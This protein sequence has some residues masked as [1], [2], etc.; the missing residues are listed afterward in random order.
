[1][2]VSFDSLGTGLG[3]QSN[4]DGRD[5]GCYEDMTGARMLDVELEETASTL[6]FYRRL[7]PNSGG[8]GYRRGG[9][10]I[11]SA[12]QMQGMQ[13]AQLTVFSNVTRIPSTSPGA[14]LPGSGTGNRIFAGGLGDGSPTEIGVRL[15]SPELDA[16]GEVPPSHATN[17]QIGVHDVMRTHSAG[18]SGLGDPLFREP[19]RVAEDLENEMITADV[20]PTIYGVVL[21]AD[22]QPDEDAT[23]QRR[24]EIRA[25]RLGAE[26]SHEPAPM[27]EY[28][29]PMRVEARR[30]VCN[31]CDQPIAATSGNWKDGAASRSWPL[32]DRVA[33]MGTKVRP[34]SVIAM[35]MWEHCCPSCGT[36]LEA[37]IW[38]EGE[39]P[40]HDV[41]LGETSDA[42]GEPF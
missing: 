16:G 11:D 10:A 21:G 32:D 36:L 42:P 9:M 18:G 37:E 27:D 14:G 13:K 29:S 31:H 30:F 25:E 33:D 35:A 20:V 34:T 24:R 28:R 19:W 23:A 4:V 3:A 15:R 40:A 39:A 12:W 17:L 1:V 8:H 2:W 6:H 38:P 41:R 22:G 26:P 5:C 7:L